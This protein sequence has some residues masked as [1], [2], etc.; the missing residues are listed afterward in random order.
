[1]VSTIA[2]IAIATAGL[3]HRWTIRIAT[4]TVTRKRGKVDC[5]KGGSQDQAAT[6]R[7][8]AHGIAP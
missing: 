1:V 2:G 6:P 4:I 5:Q 7:V 3:G 8:E